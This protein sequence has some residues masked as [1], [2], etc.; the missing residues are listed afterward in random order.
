MMFLNTFLNSVKKKN[1]LLHTFENYAFGTSE[2][3]N[4]IE[5]PKSGGRFVERIR[6][7]MRGSLIGVVKKAGTPLCDPQWAL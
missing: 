3:D 4:P 7:S 1:I 5:D 2:V 6:G